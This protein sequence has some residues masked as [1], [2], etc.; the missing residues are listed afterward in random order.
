MSFSFDNIRTFQ[1]NYKSTFVGRSY[2][3][4]IMSGDTLMIFKLRRKLRCAP[5]AALRDCPQIPATPAER[6]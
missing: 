3:L 4:P 5:A 2:C 1:H 6:C